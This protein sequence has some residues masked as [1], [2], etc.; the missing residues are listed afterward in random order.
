VVAPLDPGLA[1]FDPAL[2][3]LAASAVGAAGRAYEMEEI[4]PTF[5]ALSV[6]LNAHADVNSEMIQ[7]R[8][9]LKRALHDRC[10]VRLPASNTRE[11]Q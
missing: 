1:H 11:I 7:L 9:I 6:V 10:D 4:R 8:R 5:L 3:D 2:L